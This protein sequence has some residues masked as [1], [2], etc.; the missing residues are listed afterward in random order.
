VI[1]E[2]MGNPEGTD[3]GKEW[4]EIYNAT[5]GAVDLKGLVL[6]VSNPDGTREKS[7]AMDSI[8][9]DPGDYLV[10][11]GVLPEFKPP[12]MDYGYA[13]DL[14]SLGNT[15]GRIAL[16]CNSTDVAEV[17]YGELASGKAKGLDGTMTPDYTAND[18]TDNWCESENEY[19]TGQFGTP[20]SVNDAC[21][22][23]AP[24]DCNDGGSPRAVVS[25]AVGDLVISEVMP[26]PAAV[27]DALGEWFEVYVAKD[28][29]I[30]GLN[31]GT[32]AGEPKAGVNSADCLR[33]TAGSYL[34]FARNADMTMNGGL[35][36]LTG[37]FSFSL[38]NT[39][40]SLFIGVG[41][42]VLDQVT[43]ASS[44]TGKARGLDP[45]KLDPTEN[46]T[47]EFW[48][49]ADAPT[50]GAGDTGTP[51]AENGSCDIP[52]PAGQCYDGVNLRAIVKPM[53]ADVKITELM[54]NPAGT[55][56]DADMEWIEVRFAADADLNGLEF[57]ATVGTVQSTFNPSACVRVTAGTHAVF[58]RK[59]SADTG[60]ITGAQGEFDF[61]LLQGGSTLFVGIDGGALDTIT[62][63][64]SSSRDGQSYRVDEGDDTTWCFS[65]T[66]STMYGTGGYG[67]PGAVNDNACM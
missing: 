19:D 2:I 42:T 16:R 37:T 30:N 53:A 24:T 60:G 54:P 6:L 33:V 67:T 25:P 13:A 44:G 51:G 65:S 23:V 63:A 61:S 1:T 17:L 27:D 26:N 34:V 36:N 39:G 32:V 38:T 64:S 45:T 40:G 3:E 18:N 12:Y 7:H 10:V 4:F 9:L 50:Y 20:G 58:T 55:G 66:A 62:Y 57:G 11:G 35:T 46:D 14:G 31:F 21:S 5:T 41:T 48:C 52:P 56:T 43:W 49:N 15:G 59:G 28:V 22:I 47:A 29:D 8:V